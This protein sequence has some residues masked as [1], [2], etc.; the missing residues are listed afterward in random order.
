MVVMYVE[1]EPDIGFRR[2]VLSDVINLSGSFF[3]FR[4]RSP[5][6][7]CKDPFSDESWWASIAS[8]KQHQLEGVVIAS[9]F[10]PEKLFNVC[11]P[12][13]DGIEDISV[14]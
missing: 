4:M 8:K 9:W 14:K 3:S 12:G 11:G 5:M 7:R 1:I 6:L 2:Q 13:A 10:L